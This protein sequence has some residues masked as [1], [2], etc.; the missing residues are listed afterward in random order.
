MPFDSFGGQLDSLPAG[1]TVTITACPTLGLDATIEWAGRAAE[2]GYEV[3]PHL[4]ARYVEDERELDDIAT[5]FVDAVMRDVLFA[6]GK[7]YRGDRT[8]PPLNSSRHSKTSTTTSTTSVSR[9]IRKDT[10][11]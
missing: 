7:R 1:A 2:Q 6:D 5:R 4:A 10:C 8:V 11:F 9:G 3:V